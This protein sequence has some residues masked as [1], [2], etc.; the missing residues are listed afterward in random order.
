M[1]PVVLRRQKEAIGDY[2]TEDGEVAVTGS[3]NSDEKIIEI[4]V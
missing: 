2:E 1:E 3:F 4:L